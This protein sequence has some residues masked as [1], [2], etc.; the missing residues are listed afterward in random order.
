[1]LREAIATGSEL[2]QTVKSYMDRGALVPDDVI[3]D[4][5]IERIARPDAQDGF[6]LDGF[7]RNLPQA[8][9]LDEAL[10][11]QGRAIDLALKLAVPDD[12][13]VERLRSS[14]ICRKCGAIYQ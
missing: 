8:K 1:M 3:I 6:I 5:L 13:L 14:W 2:G 10:T 11:A 4:M 7:P 12:E 9:A